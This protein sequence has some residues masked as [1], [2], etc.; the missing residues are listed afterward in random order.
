MLRPT[1]PDCG[2]P[3]VDHGI[4]AYEFW[5]QRGRDVQWVCEVCEEAPPPPPLRFRPGSPAPEREAPFWPFPTGPK[6]KE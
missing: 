4:G 1:C 3:L 6:P 2:N 5:G